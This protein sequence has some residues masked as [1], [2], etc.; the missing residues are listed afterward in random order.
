M[1]ALKLIS[2]TGFCIFIVPIILVLAAI[3]FGSSG[4]VSESR[5]KELQ[6]EFDNDRKYLRA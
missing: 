6:S 3:L 4:Q 2:I 1:L 5:L